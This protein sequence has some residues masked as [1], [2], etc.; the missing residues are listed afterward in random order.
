VGGGMSVFVVHHQH[1]ADRCPATD[2]TA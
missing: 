2:F 1:P